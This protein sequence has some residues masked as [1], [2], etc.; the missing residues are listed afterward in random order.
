MPTVS[1]AVE[2]Q[3]SADHTVRRREFWKNH[4]GMMVFAFLYILIN[5]GLFAY[6]QYSYWDTK[7]VYVLVARGC[8]K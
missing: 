2:E 4:A 8:G 3:K 7:R 1:P 5:V 6:A